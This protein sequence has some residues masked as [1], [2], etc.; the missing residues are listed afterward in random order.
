M[1]SWGCLISQNHVVFGR[2][3]NYNNKMLFLAKCATNKML[4]KDTLLLVDTVKTDAYGNFKFKNIDKQ[5]KSGLYTI[6]L[7]N[8]KTM[9]FILGEKNVQLNSV[10]DINPYFNTVMDSASSKGNDNENKIFYEFIKYKRSHE[11]G[12]QTLLKL[13]RVFPKTDPFYDQILENYNLKFISLQNFVNKNDNKNTMAIKFAN[14]S[15]IPVNPD[16]KQRDEW[17][18]SVYVHHYFDL[19]NPID[20][21][22]L[23]NGLLFDKMEEFFK[24]AI[25]K[26]D[27]YGKPLNDI[28]SIQANAAITFINRTITDYNCY[29]ICLNYFLKKFK[30]E[31]KEEAFL[32]LYDNFLKAKNNDCGNREQDKLTWAHK[33]A[34][35]IRKLKIGNFAPN[36]KF[37]SLGND[38]NGI[39]SNYTMIIFWATWCP[40][41]TKEIPQ[42]K[43][44][45][46]NYNY[47]NNNEISV[48]SV[49][50]DEN[51]TELN[52]YINA[53]GLNSWIN[54]CEYM[55]WHSDIAKLYNIYS[56]PTIILLSEDK[57]IISKPN[58]LSELQSLLTNKY[59]LLSTKNNISNQ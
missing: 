5:F 17:R 30:L 59:K 18:D 43:K 33:N 13:L 54:Y 6:F 25:N 27:I 55:G 21:F 52:D 50:L 39:K 44:L 41:C 45:V 3:K 53:K 34:D 28:E 7:T 36:F 37:D 22:Y 12:Q 42:I 24:L 56:T 1:T 48:I 35:E 8:N 14:A 26:I 16:W 19:F 57:K 40:H 10:F 31:H 49:S 15:F 38:L 46:D 2:I 20:S 11:L 58:D 9:T 23:D 47:N 51:R 32:I 4:T 29:H